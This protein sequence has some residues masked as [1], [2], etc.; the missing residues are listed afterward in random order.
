[1]LV[2]FL[3]ESPPPPPL[4]FSG[5]KCMLVFIFFGPYHIGGVVAFKKDLFLRVSE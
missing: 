1:M 3:C 2:L 5:F 4:F